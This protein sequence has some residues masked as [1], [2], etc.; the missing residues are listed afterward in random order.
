MKIN[1]KI[2]LVLVS[3]ASLSLQSCLVAAIGAGVGSWKFGDAKKAEAETKCKKSYPTYYMDMQKVNQS[4]ARAHQKQEVIMT[5]EEYC[6][7]EKDEDKKKD[8]K[9]VSVT[10]AGSTASQNAN[11]SSSK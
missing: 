2:G 8:E 5:M 11:V 7:L 1:T 9:K 10:T 6:H 4:K 3:V